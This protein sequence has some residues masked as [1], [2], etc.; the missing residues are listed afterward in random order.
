M[1]VRQLIA[2]EKVLKSDTG[3]SARDLPPR[4]APIYAKTR[5]IRAGWRWRSAAC[6]SAASTRFI[7]T[8]L[9]NPGRDN[10]QAFLIVET[11]AGASVIARFEYHGSHP[12]LHGHAHCEKGGIEVGASGLDNLVRIPKAQQSHRRTNA[13]TEQTFWDAARRFFRVKDQVR[14]DQLELI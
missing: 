7:L 14:G 2:K 9:G 1:R 13:W 12:G 11:D 10:W 4:H 3:W 8:A 6:E 5:P